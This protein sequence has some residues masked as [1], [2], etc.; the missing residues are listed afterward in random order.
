MEHQKMTAKLWDNGDVD[1]FVEDHSEDS[2]IGVLFHEENGYRFALNRNAWG[3]VHGE[4]FAKRLN[5]AIIPEFT[6][7]E[8]LIVVRKVYEAEL[9]EWEEYYMMQREWEDAQA[10]L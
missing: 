5:G 2:C 1:L 7:K 8:V 3:K 9:R 10:G 4:L 6:L